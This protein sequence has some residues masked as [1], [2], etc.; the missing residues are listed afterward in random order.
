MVSI[1]LPVK[2][3]KI[4]LPLGITA[5]LLVITSIG[6][7]LIKFIFGLDILFN[8][9]Y[10]DR[11]QNI[12]T[13][14][15]ALLLIIAALLLGFIAILNRKKGISH[16]SEWTI[17][18]LGFLVMAF[19]EAFQVH[20]KMIVPVR[21]LIGAG[22]FGFF[23]YAWVIPGILLIVFLGIYF[24]RFFMD[25]SQKTRI[26]F[27]IA[28]ILFV[29]GAVGMEL[30]GGRY[31]ELYGVNNLTYS[32]IACVEE[33]LEMAGVIIF[34]RALLIYFQDNYHE[35]HLMF[36]SPNTKEPDIVDEVINENQESPVHE[37]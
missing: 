11:E 34:I 27:L 24:F 37:S 16:I 30:I 15:S 12:P 25:L 2:P 33:G 5:F 10:L 7:Q 21:S 28:A 14:F 36:S 17:L 13:Y 26:N 19:D 9:F 8:L 22:N 23:Y 32:M 4:V 18:S 6:T 29:G 1:K 35:V 20:E 31:A 3:F